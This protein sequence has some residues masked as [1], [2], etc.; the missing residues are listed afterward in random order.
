MTVAIGLDRDHAADAANAHALAELS[1]VMLNLDEVWHDPVRVASVR[2]D[3]IARALR[4]HLTRNAPY[5]AYAQSFGLDVSAPE[6]WPVDAIPLLPSSFFK[7]KGLAL[8]T[9]A[10]RDIVKRCTSS[11]TRG[12]LSIVDRDEDTLTTFLGSMSSSSCLYDLDR[13]G[14]NKAFVLG[15]DPDEA[16]DLW[17]SYVLATMALSLHTEYLERRGRFDAGEAA[18]AIDGAVARGA[19]PV[20]VGPP[21][22]IAELCRRL[23]LERRTIPLPPNSFIIS[24]GGWKNR[25]N[26]AIPRDSFATLVQSAFEVGPASVRDSYNMVELNSVL[27]ECEHHEK[28]VMPWLDVHAR[29]PRTN[30]VV[31]DG[32][33][34]VLAFCDGS[35]FSYPCF[36]LSEDYGTTVDGRCACG[37]YGQRVRIVRRLEGVEA[38]GCALKMAGGSEVNASTRNRFFKSF[39][40]RP[41]LYARRLER[42]RHD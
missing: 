16:G 12:S 14:N 13:S 40:R 3:T 25:E 33:S 39:Y 36:V 35:A 27:N 37:R 22:R 24:G 15:P 19:S 17:F 8:S 32:E 9:A 1:Y 29:D 42:D 26:D 20:I 30:A 31:R 18:A 5:R 28:H 21:F 10:P 2:R 11:G 7:R 34:G 6:E 23:E 38:R 4:A 41:D